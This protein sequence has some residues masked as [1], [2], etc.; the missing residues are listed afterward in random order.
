MFWKS[1]MRKLQVLQNKVLRLQTRMPYGT[2]TSN[3]LA[4]ANQLS[5]HQLIAYYS[6]TKVYKIISS[7]QPHHYK[8]L[9]TD[10]IVGPGTRSLQDY[11]IEFKLYIGRGRFFYRASRLWAA[12]PDNVKRSNKVETFKRACRKWTTENILVKP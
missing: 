4:K 9:V 11:I 3:L 2:P 10:D 6:M 1:D 7:K 12:L 8:R 5:V